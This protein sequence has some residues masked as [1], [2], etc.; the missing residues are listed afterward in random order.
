MLQHA[1]MHHIAMQIP[2]VS[3]VGAAAAVQWHTPAAVI[4][5]AKAA[6]IRRAGYITK[7]SRSPTPVPG[8]GSLTVT[9]QAASGSA[10]GACVLTGR[11]G[12]DNFAKRVW[13][14]MYVKGMSFSLCPC[15]FGTKG[16]TYG[17][18]DW[19]AVRVVRSVQIALLQTAAP[20]PGAR[21]LQP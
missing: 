17:I 21:D 6:N 18:L 5:P 9:T 10:A 11:T 8:V 2:D 14:N 12:Q 3:M 19:Q 7:S 13:Q 16:I 4:V 20:L 1:Y 15:P